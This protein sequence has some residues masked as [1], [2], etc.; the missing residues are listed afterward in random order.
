MQWKRMVCSCCRRGK[1]ARMVRN[2]RASVI[3]MTR[4]GDCP[5]GPVDTDAKWRTTRH[6]R[7]PHLYYQ[8][9]AIVER[10]GFI[11]ARKTTH[12]SGGDWQAFIGILPQLPISRESLAADTGYNDARLRNHL[13]DLAQ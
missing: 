13:K 2:G 11:V 9:N 12:A 8:E 5:L 4:R 10:G 6:D 1:L 3:T 7:R